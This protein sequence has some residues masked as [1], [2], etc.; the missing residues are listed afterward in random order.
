MLESKY[1]AVT[2]RRIVEVISPI[3]VP[4]VDNNFLFVGEKRRD[5]GRSKFPSRSEQEDRHVE[6]AVSIVEE[7]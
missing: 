5:E 6:S 1:T 7:S 4:N 2:L 3:I